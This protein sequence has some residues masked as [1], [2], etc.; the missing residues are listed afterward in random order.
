ME[1]L[2]D[3][4][5]HVHYGF[6]AL[7]PADWAVGSLG[8]MLESIGGQAN[9]ICGARVP[10]AVRMQT[11]LHTG[12]VP[13]RVERHDERPGVADEWEDVVEVSVTLTADEYAVKAFDTSEP[14]GTIPAGDYRARWC[15]AGMDAGHELD[16][17]APGESAPDRYLL[18]LWPQDPASDEVLRQTSEQAASWHGVAA[19]TPAVDVAQLRAAG[20]SES[21]DGT[22]FVPPDSESSWQVIPDE[23]PDEEP[24]DV[25]MVAGADLSWTLTEVLTDDDPAP[26]HAMW[27]DRPPNDTLR[28][29]AQGC[30]ELTFYD[31]DLLDELTGLS[32]RVLRALAVRA[33]R[34]LAERAGGA[35]LPVVVDALDVVARGGTLPPVWH[36]WDTAHAIFP[37]QEGADDEVA[38]DVELFDSMRSGDDAPPHIPLSVDIAAVEAIRRAADPHDGRAAAHA[39]SALI[40]A[41]EDPDLAMAEIR[42]TIATLRAT[43]D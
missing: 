18:Q 21:D 42:T 9:G 38:L 27:G 30:V 17:P 3:G 19:Q 24:D 28:E 1:V 25:D 36:D 11:G 12:E 2:F 13:V 6:L 41:S 16:T 31:R 4:G 20:W 10:H 40:G 8:F 22:G 32:P 14:V 23:W 33:T 5:V 37:A 35:D 29:W 39:L 15:A 43:G 26:E 7:E 34:T